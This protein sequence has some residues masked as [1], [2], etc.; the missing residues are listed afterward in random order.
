LV[1]EF[2]H[3]GPVGDA[4]SGKWRQAATTMRSPVAAVVTEVA[5]VTTSDEFAF[6]ELLLAS[7]GDVATPLYSHT[8]PTILSE[9]PGVRVMVVS[10]PSEIF[11]QV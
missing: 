4:A 7:S 1:K 6:V 10:V 5:V 3:D 2:V 9:A 11:H 8:V